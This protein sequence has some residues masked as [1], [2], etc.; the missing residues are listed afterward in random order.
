MSS[1]ATTVR[2]L[3]IKIINK[4]KLNYPCASS[5]DIFSTCLPFS[6]S[7]TNDCQFSFSVCTWKS[8]GKNSITWGKFP[9]K[10]FTLVMVLLNWPLNQIHIRLFS[11]LRWFP[12]LLFFS[13][14]NVQHTGVQ[15]SIVE[16]LIQHHDWFFP[17]GWWWFC[18]S[19]HLMCARSAVV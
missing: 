14:V 6:R 4:R 12:S 13:G 5:F 10:I 2:A 19:I 16:A 11:C 3:Q 8:S 7:R 15:S 17:G 18:S 9:H 1:F